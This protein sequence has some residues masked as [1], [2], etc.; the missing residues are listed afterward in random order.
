[1]ATQVPAIRGTGVAGPPKWVSLFNP[2]ARFLLRAGIPLGPN[3]LLTVRGRRSGLPRTT[4]VAIIELDGRR[5]IWAPWG[6]VN[7]TQ[8][9]RASG[10]AT[11]TKRGRSEELL[12]TELTAEQRIGFFRDDLRRLASSIPGG[13]WFIRTVDGVDLNDP[14]SA[15]VGRPVFELHAPPS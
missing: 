14:V 1:M 10:R 15:A 4:P 6:N 2:I 13:V 8:N 9:L 12:A 11:I 3:G 5:W 7:W